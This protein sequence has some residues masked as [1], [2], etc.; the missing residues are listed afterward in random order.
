MK[1]RVLLLSV[2]LLAAFPLTGAA[3]GVAHESISVWLSKPDGIYEVGDSAKVFAR[4]SKDLGPLRFTVMD[5]RTKIVD[6]LLVFGSD[7][8]TR[9]IYSEYCDKAGGKMFILGPDGDEKHVTAAGYVV[10]PSTIYPGYTAPD[11]LYSWW[12]GQIA[13]MR[14]SRP[15]VTSREVPVPAKYKDDAIRCW[16]VT[17]SMPEGNPVQ[18]YVAMPQKAAKKSLPIVIRTH[19][20]TAITSKSTRSSLS[21]ACEFASRGA[22]AAD[23]NAHG[24][25]DDAPEEYYR[26]LSKTLTG[27][28]KR[29]LES[30]EGFYFRLMFLRLERLADYLCSFREW[31]RTRFMVRGGSQGGAQSLFLAG[32]DP[33]VTHCLAMVPAMTDFGGPLQGRAAAWPEPYARPGV[34]ESEA[35]MDIL[36]YFDASLLVKRFKGRLFL[37]AGFIDTTCPATCIYA[38]YNNAS[39]A[40]ERV[41]E[42]YVYRRH[43]C[44]DPP[45]S[46]HWS[47]TVVAHRNRFMDDFYNGR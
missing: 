34:A 33:R 42:P 21:Q 19:G 23:I 39:C 1:N 25:P 28:N 9:V 3:L 17:I 5:G 37:E 44:V 13:K 35:G 7:T 18:A 41:I 29:P 11:D 43:C 26:E 27:Y 31:D 8:T 32:V 4:C 36:P 30:R 6:T 24:M 40:K 46:E 2:L 14:K 38:T 16:H 47:G 10:A 12:E 22:I 45:Y 15:K 20:A